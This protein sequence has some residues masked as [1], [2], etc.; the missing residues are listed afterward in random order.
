KKNIHTKTISSRMWFFWPMINSKEELPVP[1]EKKKQLTIL[2]LGLKKL[3]LHPKE[4]K[5]TCKPLPLPL[6]PTRIRKR[7]LLH[8]IP[9]ERLPDITSSGFWTTMHLTRL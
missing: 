5:A 4:H 6:K 2:P 3:E 1:K 8:R 9:Q 7:Y